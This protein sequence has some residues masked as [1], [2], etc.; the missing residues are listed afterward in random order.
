MKQTKNFWKLLVTVNMSTYVLCRGWLCRTTVIKIV[1]QE[2]IIYDVHVRF[3]SIN[4]FNHAFVV[5]VEQQNDPRALNISSVHSSTRQYTLVTHRKVSKTKTSHS[6]FL[7]PVLLFQSAWSL[8]PIR[9]NYVSSARAQRVVYEGVGLACGVLSSGWVTQQL[10]RSRDNSRSRRW[11]LQ[12]SLKLSWKNLKKLYF[13]R[14]GEF[15]AIFCCWYFLF[16]S[17]KLIHKKMYRS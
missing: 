6:N 2:C 13:G 17:Q 9:N 4:E 15:F 5:S 8:I 7:C 3:H 10:S 11:A 14:N 12:S 16:Q 1:M